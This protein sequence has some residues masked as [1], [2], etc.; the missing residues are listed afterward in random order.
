MTVSAALRTALFDEETDDGLLALLT[1]DHASLSIPIQVVNNKVD[2][3]R[4]DTVNSPTDRTAN[5]NTAVFVGSP[6]YVAGLSSGGAGR[7]LN[8]EPTQSAGFGSGTEFDLGSFTFEFWIEPETLQGTAGSYI[9]NVM[10]GR[11][12][13]ATKGFRYGYNVD[14]RVQFWSTESGGSLLVNAGSNI[15]TAGTAAHLAITYD[16]STTTARLV[17]NGATIATS[18]GTIVIPT[19]VAMELNDAVGGGTRGDATYDE[20]RVWNFAR[21][22]NAILRDLNKRSLGNETG[23]VGFWPWSGQKVFVGL[24]FGIILPT[25]EAGSPPS[26]RLSIDN[27]SREIIAAVRTAT[28]AAPT[29]QIEVVR[30]LDNDAVELTFPPLNLRNVRG[31]ADKVT[32][33]LF[34]EDLQTEPYP[35]DRFTPGSFPGLF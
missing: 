14:G 24:P 13:A 17:L 20:F 31:V 33:D 12:V 21:S 26:A 19:G 5:A 11:E 2:V 16:L 4:H 8:F 32:G 22:D 28:G 30:I 1:I 29:V 9:S 10:M 6:T 27:V 18:T 7:A 35:A 15:L 25:D 23:L 34:S 3:H